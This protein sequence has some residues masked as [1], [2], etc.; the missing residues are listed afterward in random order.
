MISVL[1][2]DFDVV[3]LRRDVKSLDFVCDRNANGEQDGSHCDGGV[4]GWLVTMRQ[5]GNLQI[6]LFSNC[7]N[8]IILKIRAKIR[9]IGLVAFI[10]VSCKFAPGI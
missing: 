2:D 4:Q 3:M 7:D 5:K 1:K 8:D 6:I 10:Y 9:P